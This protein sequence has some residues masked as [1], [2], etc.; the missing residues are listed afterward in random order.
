VLAVAA[1]GFAAA[2]G[3]AA[4][5]LGRAPLAVVLGILLLGGCCGPALTG[6]LTSQLAD[7]VDADVLPRAYG[8]DSLTYNVS[9]ILGPAAGAAVAG[10]VSP[11]VATVAL[12]AS[13]A[14][15]ALLIV[16]L[17][18]RARPRSRTPQERTPLLTGFAATL[19]D[20]VLGVVTVA[21]SVGQL[22]PAGLPVV[23]AILAT[24]R[25]HPASSGWL[26]TAIAVGGLLGS[27]WW[28]W[29]PVAAGR[30]PLVVT[31]ALVGV[32]APLALAALAS[33]FL[34]V[35]ALFALSGIFLGPYAGAL[36]TVRQDRAPDGL[37]AQVFTI[38]AGLKTT[39]AAAGAALAGGLAGLP[40]TGQLLVAAAGP[41]LAGIGGAVFLIGWPTRGR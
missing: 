33:S 38:G 30:A 16:V 17:P 22:G 40:V 2:L 1:L 15:G 18:T 4:L 10:L 14:V 11:D 5:L 8:L 19:R 6:G 39:A 3:S 36:F 23:V 21:S 9:G 25:G 35:A 37:Q 31:L 7:L 26:L 13:A 27:L 41:C 12:A 20:R 28:T 34:T 24:Q 29:R 32:G